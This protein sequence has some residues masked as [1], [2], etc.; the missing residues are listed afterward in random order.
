MSRREP[1][2][3]PSAISLATSPGRHPAGVAT[4]FAP[5]APR[6]TAIARPRANIVN[7]MAIRWA[8]RSP[9]RNVKKGNSVISCPGGSGGI[10][11]VL[12]QKSNVPNGVLNSQTL[13]IP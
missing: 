9:K 13:T 4:P 5:R 3:T 10:T 2:T 1:T 6:T 12:R 11:R 8:W 7:G